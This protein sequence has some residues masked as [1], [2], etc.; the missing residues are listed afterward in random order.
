MNT[1]TLVL[2]SVILL[3]AAGCT[4]PSTTSS[5]TFERGVQVLGAGSPRCA[6]PL[7]SQVIGSIPDGPEP[8]AMLAMAYALDLQ[9]DPA[10]KQANVARQKRKPAENP[11]WE[12]VAAGIA[13]LTQHR[14]AEA[15]KNFGQILTTAQRG[16]GIRNAAGL[17]MTLTLLL[18]GDSREA[19]ALL[20]QESATDASAGRPVTPLLWSV[21]IYG[22]E[23]NTADAAKSLAALAQEVTVSRGA[24]A[25]QI[26]DLSACTDLELR[27]C[28]I[29]GVRQGRLKQAREMFAALHERTPGPGDV[30]VWLALVS[31]AQGDWRQAQDDL[32]VACQSGPRPSQSLANH[33]AGVAAT[34][35]RNPQKMI[36]HI[37]T[38]QRLAIFAPDVMPRPTEAQAEKVW[39]SDNLN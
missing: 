18:M 23:G 39:A 25:I 7:F 31:A 8:H 3:L 35:E 10:L 21:M 28:G 15:Q 13:A 12:C 26:T 1:R 5:L 36:G 20:E 34:F 11:G 2:V 32:R 27:E 30:R 17:W 19:M 38:G 22:H 33:L 29:V 37:L 14:P 16:S 6:I 24:E 4:R 9:P